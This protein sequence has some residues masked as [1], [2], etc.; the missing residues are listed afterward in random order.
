MTKRE[1]ILLVI[2]VL[3]VALLMVSI[4]RHPLLWRAAPASPYAGLD[5]QK[6]S[7]SIAYEVFKPAIVSYNQ[8]VDYF[9]PSNLH[10]FYYVDVLLELA[11]GYY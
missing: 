7:P 2:L 1:G 10:Q 4:V 5:V 9:R 11:R 3:L 6:R 8:L